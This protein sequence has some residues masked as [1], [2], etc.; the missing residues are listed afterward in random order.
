[1]IRLIPTSLG[2]IALGITLG[3]TS[4]LVAPAEASAIPAFARRY[5]T[6]CHSCHQFHYPRLNSFG[7]RFR[8]NGYQYPDGAEDPARAKRM[9]EPGTL[10]E[11][12]TVFK[13]V[14]LSL[15]AQVFG[16]G[17]ADA[18][19]RDQPIFD[20]RLFSFLIGGGSV[21]KDVSFFFTWTPFPDPSVHQARIG[22]HNIGKRWLG[23]GSLNVR[24]GAL[25]LLDFQRP[26]HRFL[27]PGPNSVSGVTVGMNGF[28]L[29]EPTLG[30]HVYGRPLS[31]P[32]LYEV[33]LVSG[34]H[35][36][37]FT[38]RDDW[39]DVFAR[40]SYTLFF[41][42]QHEVT[43]GTFG[44]RG[45]SDIEANIGG[46]DLAFRDDFYIAGLDLEVDV[47]PLNLTGMAYYSRHSD[48]SPERESVEFSAVRAEAFWQITST[49]V[50]SL[51]YEQVIAAAEHS[52]MR[53]QQIAP[54]LTYVIATNVLATV[55]WRYDLLAPRRGSSWVG[56][57]E[58]TF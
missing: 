41:N 18:P 30:V 29:D 6:T 14:P 16:V 49:W 25:F 26:G 9:V 12:L 7:R 33:A 27:A 35:D 24:A 52:E 37:A 23:E 1:M 58:S 22:L 8:E 13:E 34:D 10:A 21:A 43:V 53:R 40:L 47:G 45:R 46:I 56:V 48:P 54:H 3:V 32:L 19:K 5:E 42:S 36:E 4:S 15:R 2:P 11:V 50:T 17:R 39:K 51:R 38:D 44:Y 20:Y 55:A 31:G 57:L 28:N